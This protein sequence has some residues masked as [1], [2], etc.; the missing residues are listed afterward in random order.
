MRERTDVDAELE[1]VSAL[2]IEVQDVFKAFTNPE[3]ASQEMVQHAKRA[4]LLLEKA[5]R[6]LEDVRG[7][8]EGG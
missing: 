5:R 8:L 3:V 6:D 2:L 1:R 7:E 4:S